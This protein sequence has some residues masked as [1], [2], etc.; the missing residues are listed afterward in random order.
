MCRVVSHLNVPYNSVFQL[1]CPL[2]PFSIAHFYHLFPILGS[3]SIA[4][5]CHLSPIIGSFNITHF[6]FVVILVS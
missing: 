5:F 4:H 6:Y 1:K 3:F 2:E